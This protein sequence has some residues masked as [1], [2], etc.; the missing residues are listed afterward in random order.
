MTG[1]K[2]ESYFNKYVLRRGV[3]VGRVLENRMS[4]DVL[5]QMLGARY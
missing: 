4:E 1:V 3:K 2:Y 5:F